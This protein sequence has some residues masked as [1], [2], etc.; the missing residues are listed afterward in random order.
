MIEIKDLVEKY[1][2]YGFSYIFKKFMN[3]ERTFQEIEILLMEYFY[4]QIHD[5]RI[6][7]ETEL[8]V[9]GV[10][11]VDLMYFQSLITKEL[12]RKGFIDGVKD[13]IPVPIEEIHEYNPMYIEY[14][15]V[16]GKLLIL[17]TAGYDY[18]FKTYKHETGE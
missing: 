2:R 14:S 4:P 1:R 11:E 13:I 12:K 7:L 15:L 9:T 18:P 8:L 6:S 5:I 3:P 17:T 10:D 16:N